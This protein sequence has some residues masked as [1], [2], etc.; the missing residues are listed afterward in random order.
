MLETVFRFVSSFR[1]GTSEQTDEPFRSDQSAAQGYWK[2]FQCAEAN[3]LDHSGGA[4]PQ[5][6]IEATS[7]PILNARGQQSDLGLAQPA[8]P[9][10]AIL[11]DML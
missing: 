7:L 1:Q 9:C 6:H 11:N 2:V 3:F 10:P 4:L 8:V 5:H